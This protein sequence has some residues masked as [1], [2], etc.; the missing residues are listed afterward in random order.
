MNEFRLEKLTSTQGHYLLRKD[1][2]NALRTARFRAINSGVPW[3]VQPWKP[4]RGNRIYIVLPSNL[5]GVTKE[6]LIKFY[7]VK[8]YDVS[9]IRGKKFVI[10]KRR[11]Y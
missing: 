3:T 7:K 1:L 4:V 10:S 2:N 9:H 8:G 6:F 11:L 5:K